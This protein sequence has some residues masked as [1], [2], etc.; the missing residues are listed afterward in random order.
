MNLSRIQ[1][2]VNSKSHLEVFCKKV[3]LQILQISQK[4][5]CAR[6]SF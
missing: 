2:P 6:A 3:F 4:N 1:F 5:T